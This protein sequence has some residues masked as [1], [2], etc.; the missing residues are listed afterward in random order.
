M[1]SG[2]DYGAGNCHK[3][4]QM[5][6]DSVS[7]HSLVQHRRRRYHAGRWRAGHPVLEQD[8]PIFWVNRPATGLLE[9][10]LFFDGS[11]IDLKVETPRAEWA[12]ASVDHWGE[13]RLLTDLCPGKPL[14]SRP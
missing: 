12:I 6:A 2:H 4:L 1:L 11:V 9:G 8:A 10:V 5:A 7:K 14:R 3:P 13:I